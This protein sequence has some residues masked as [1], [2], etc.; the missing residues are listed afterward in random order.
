MAAD[1][2]QAQQKSMVLSHWSSLVRMGMLFGQHRDGGGTMSE[3]NMSYQSVP[4]SLEDFAKEDRF[5]QSMCWRLTDHL[6]S[7]QYHAIMYLFVV[8]WM[9]CPAIVLFAGRMGGELGAIIAVLSVWG[10]AFATDR[11]ILKYWV[12]R[13]KIGAV[14]EFVS[15]D[16]N[17]L[18]GDSLDICL[19][20]DIPPNREKEAYQLFKLNAALNMLTN[21]YDSKLRSDGFKG[22]DPVVARLR[23]IAEDKEGKP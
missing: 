7:K 1:P 14:L 3:T 4:S 13:E 5:Y 11:A 9:V 15:G 19:R 20:L 21:G 2:T 6:E 17:P 16:W 10:L 22:F 12:P 18:G 8:L 23:I